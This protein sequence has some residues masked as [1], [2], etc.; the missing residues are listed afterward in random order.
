ML[1]WLSLPASFIPCKVRFESM[2]DDELAKSPY[3]VVN[4][5]LFILCDIGFFNFIVFI[6]PR[7]AAQLR[8][9]DDMNVFQALWAAVQCKPILPRR[10]NRNSV[11]GAGENTPRPRRISGLG[12]TGNGYLLNARRSEENINVGR[13]HA[14]DTKLVSTFDHPSSSCMHDSQNVVSVDVT[15]SGSTLLESVPTESDTTPSSSLSSGFL[16]L[17]SANI[18]ASPYQH[19]VNGSELLESIIEKKVSTEKGKLSEGVDGDEFDQQISTAFGENG[20]CSLDHKDEEIGLV[21]EDKE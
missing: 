12:E 20:F 8:G 5:L 15:Y 7:V 21:L 3:R 14:T 18:S 17:V 10:R 6:F 13:D 2:L 16:S 9:S 11:V 4:S 19:S 1:R